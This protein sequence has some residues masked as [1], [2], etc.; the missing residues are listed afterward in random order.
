MFITANVHE[1]F[2]F[3]LRLTTKAT[4]QQNQDTKKENQMKI[5]LLVAFV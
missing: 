3:I 1:K 4:S 2:K 5:R